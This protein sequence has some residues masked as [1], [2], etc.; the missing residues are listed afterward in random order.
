MSRAQSQATPNHP[1]EHELLGFKHFRRL[2][3]CLERLAAQAQG[4]NRKLEYHHY[5]TALLFYYFNPL[6]TSMRGL[7]QVSEFPRVQKRLG[8]KRFS[9]GS[10]SE[11]A[12]QRVFD[13]ELVAEI[14]KELAQQLPPSD[15]KL[16]G[17]LK[18]TQRILTAVDGTV[19][20]ALPRMAW[21]LWQDDQ[22]RAA[23][24]HV[25]FEIAKGVGVAATIT[26]GT[27]SEVEALRN[28]LEAGRCY[29]LDRGYATYSLLRDIL[30]AGSSFVVRVRSNAVF[31]VVEERELRPED[32]AVGV[33]RDVVVRLGGANTPDLHQ[34]RLRLV[35]VRT[36]THELLLATDLLTIEADLVAVIYRSR[37]Q[38]ELFFRWLK[39]V[40]GMRHLISER[41]NGVALQVYA[42]L[43]ASMLLF[44][45]TGRKPTKRTFELFC[46][47]Q[48]GWATE[49]DLARHLAKLAGAPGTKVPN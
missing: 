34:H 22:H 1:P 45:W 27:G 44:L 39:C 23:K 10:F 12:S 24:A 28:V 47:V 30:G 21:A 17:R 11:A 3:P 32:R 26:E 14:V 36:E 25:Q 35:M 13:A 48:Q 49:E 4:G 8:I 2:E 6:I 37:W 38:V 15:Q 19:L 9:L 7:Q 31:E 29:I 5:L 42:A 16:D 33:V 18:Q 43:I 20:Q 41:E 40:L 46:F